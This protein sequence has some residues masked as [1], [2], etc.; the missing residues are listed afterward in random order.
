MQHAVDVDARRAAL[1]GRVGDDPDADLAAAPAGAHRR[2]G[3]AGGEVGRRFGGQCGRDAGAFSPD[4]RGHRRRARLDEADGRRPAGKERP[5]R[6]QDMPKAWVFNGAIYLFRASLLAGPAPTLYGDR[7]AAYVM[8]PPFG[9]NIDDP[10]DWANVERLLSRFALTASGNAGTMTR[11]IRERSN[12][13]VREHAALTVVRARVRSVHPRTA[14]VYR[15]ATPI[16][17][18]DGAVA[19]LVTPIS[20]QSDPFRLDGQVAIVTGGLG[21]LGT[22]YACALVRRRRCRWCCSTLSPKPSAPL[23]ALIDAGAR[24]STHVVDATSRAAVDAAMADVAGAIRRAVDSRQQ[25]RARILAGRCRA[26]DRTIRAVSRV[27]VGRDAR[28][29]SQERVHRHAV[30]HRAVP[31]G[32]RL[33]RGQHHQCVVDLRRRLAR[34]VG[35][36]LPAARRR[37]VLQTDRLQRREVGHAEFHALARRVLRAVRR[38]GQHAGARRRPGSRRTRRS[39]S[40]STSSARRSGAWRADDDYN[41]A[42]VFLASP[43]SAYMTGAMLVVD[44]GWTA[45]DVAAASRFGAELASSEVSATRLKAE[46][47]GRKRS[48]RPAARRRRRAF[49]RAARGDRRRARAR[50]AIRSSAPSCWPT[51]AGSTRST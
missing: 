33:A 49:L 41:G 5:V 26:R 29:A 32:A 40:P 13:H 6:R 15:T 22:Q 34:P 25:R 10:E 44:G 37:G 38:A 16:P 20:P 3:G 35:V 28:L 21:R 30:L 39:S 51:S 4:A 2:I 42:I 17:V 23:Q 47:D 46:A 36:R 7:V 9:S 45:R 24:V 48:F 50:R 31:R 1:P 18:S 11:S 27:G 43:A 8:P 19:C 12:V 14:L